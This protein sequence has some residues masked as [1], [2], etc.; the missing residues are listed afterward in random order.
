MKLIKNMSPS[1]QPQFL[2]NIPHSHIGTAIREKYVVKYLFKSYF[3]DLCAAVKKLMGEK[4]GRSLDVHFF[5]VGVSNVLNTTI[6][7]LKI[8]FPACLNKCNYF[9]NTDPANLFQ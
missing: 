3:C 7:P 4:W 1:G 6:S 9:F 2:C 8:Y 5:M